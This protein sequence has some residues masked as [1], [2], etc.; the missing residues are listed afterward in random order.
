MNG[1]LRA[2]L[3]KAG[4]VCRKKRFDTRADA[5]EEAQFLVTAGRDSDPTRPFNAWWCRRCRAWHIGHVQ[6]TPES[7]TRTVGA[8]PRS[9]K[10]H[11]DLFTRPDGLPPRASSYSRPCGCENEEGD[12]CLRTAHYVVGRRGFCGHH[13][14]EAYAAAKARPMSTP[15]LS[16]TYVDPVLATVEK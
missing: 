16:A 6:V 10:K 14:R 5:L 1:Q 11:N 9:K 8:M 13:R 12:L 4:V 2:G 3:V 15:K 7:R